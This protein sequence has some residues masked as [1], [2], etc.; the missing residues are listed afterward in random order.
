MGRVR[1]TMIDS[2]GCDFCV[3]LTM[4]CITSIRVSVESWIITAR[5]FQPY[6]VTFFN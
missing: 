5:Y 6:S 3:G 1:F 2:L 4:N